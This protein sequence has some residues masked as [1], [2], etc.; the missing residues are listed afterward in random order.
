M[1]NKKRKCDTCYG[2]VDLDEIGLYCLLKDK[3]I[4]EY[5]NINDCEALEKFNKQK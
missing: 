4:D 5:V 3:I 2:S 1:K